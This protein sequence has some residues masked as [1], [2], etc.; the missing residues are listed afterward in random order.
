MASAEGSPEITSVRDLHRFDEATL[1]RFMTE[2]V[3]GFRGPLSVRQFE[4]GQS[5]PTFLLADGGGRR[6]VM[7]KKPPGELLPSAHAVDREYRVIKA[8]AD[9]GVPV[10][11]ALALCEDPS[12]IGTAFYVMAFVDGRILRRLDLPG[13]TPADRARTYDAMNDSLARIHNVDFA[14][15]GLADFGR[16]GNYFARQFSRW[17][18][19][20]EAS[21]TEEIAPMT[22]LMAWLE[23][24][25]VEDDRTTLVHGDYRLENM[26]FHPTEP[27]ILA[28]LDW[29]LATLGNPLSDIA[30]NCMPY[31]VFDQGRG[32]LRGVDLAAL[33]IP[34][35]KD[36]V[37]AYCRRTGRSEIKNWN[38]YLA[39]NCFRLAAIM[40]GVYARGLRGQAASKTALERGARAKEMAAIGAELAGA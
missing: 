2:K 5:N 13:V 30:Y 1:D 33:G 8:L 7:R 19:Q 35:E 6:Y 29:E 32:T 18:R 21:K 10:A 34:T 36:Y 12:V 4:G 39:F 26:I 3:A 16:P 28:V 17:A 25:M 23:K 40:Q 11:P 20:Y 31:Y 9:T 24:N 15:Q 14:K 37:A 22:R 27:K 38:F